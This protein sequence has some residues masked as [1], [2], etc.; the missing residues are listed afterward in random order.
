VL[1]QLGWRLTRSTSITF[2]E[3]MISRGACRFNSETDRFEGAS[4]RPERIP[5]MDDSL[6]GYSRFFCDLCV[7]GKTFYSTKLRIPTFLICAVIDMDLLL[8]R[9]SIIAM[10]ALVCSRRALKVTPE[11]SDCFG[12]LSCDLLDQHR[13]RQ[14]IELIWHTYVTQFDLPT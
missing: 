7:Q 12:A 5:N 14:Q 6:I 8:E 9:H 10:A 13:V 1:N 2:L 4:L 11:W 3:N